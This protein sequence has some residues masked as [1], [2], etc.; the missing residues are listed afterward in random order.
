[1][2]RMAKT[3]TWWKAS[4][5]GGL[6]ALGFYPAAAQAPSLAML[7][8]LT[9]GEWEIR[10]RDGSPARKICLRTGHELIQ[11]KHSA[12]GCNRY[13]VEDSPKEVTV[14]YTCSG[15]GYGRTNIR[16]ESST[17]VQIQGQGIDGSSE[18]F[19][20]SAEARRVGSC[21]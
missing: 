4:L 15:Q 20:F 10:F 17:L 14:Q 16:R 5:A 11:L 9:K 12:R 2:N 21:S 18:P 19:Q 1:M 3:G 8:Q 13:V 7:E 6:L